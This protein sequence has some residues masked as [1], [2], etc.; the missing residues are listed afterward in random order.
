[1]VA[2]TPIECILDRNHPDYL[3]MTASE[4]KPQVSGHG[5]PSN[6]LKVLLAL[7]LVWDGTLYKEILHSECCA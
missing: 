1:M 2:N 7:S 6:L 4:R 5:T 3:N